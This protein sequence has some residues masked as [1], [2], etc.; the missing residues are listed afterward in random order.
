VYKEKIAVRKIV[1]FIL[2][3]GD[4]DSRK[5][6]N[7]TAQEG[8]RIHRRLQKEAGED[9]QKEVFLKIESEIEK[10]KLIIEGRADGLFYDEGQ[11]VLGY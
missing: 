9:Y 7:H 4:I 1:E 6:S 2:R 10:D 11:T 5:V 8:A 3:Q